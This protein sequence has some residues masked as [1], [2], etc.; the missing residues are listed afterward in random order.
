M[1]TS[2]AASA[3]GHEQPAS[4]RPE[5]AASARAPRSRSELRLSPRT[6]RTR[7]AA[8]RGP[9]GRRRPPPLVPRGAR[10]DQGRSAGRDRRRRLTGSR[11]PRTTLLRRRRAELIGD[12]IEADDQ[13][14][15]AF[16]DR[17][18]AHTESPYGSRRRCALASPSGLPQAGRQRE[19]TQ[20]RLGSGKPVGHDPPAPTPSSSFPDPAPLVR[21]LVSLRLELRKQALPVVLSVRLQRRHTHGGRR[22]GPLLAS[23]WPYRFC[24]WV[25]G[26]PSASNVNSL[27]VHGADPAPDRPRRCAVSENPTT[28]GLGGPTSP[29]RKHVRLGARE[30]HP[31]RPTGS[32]R[33][34]LSTPLPKR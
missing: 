19:P 21:D 30:T 13:S 28:S 32:P 15:S 9:S 33:Q 10:T 31:T 4:H 27:V 20:S 5:P 29:R 17:P 34:P 12:V 26:Q 3:H 6:A 11:P 1:P 23:H 16:G 24:A 14:L 18:A 22:S 7:A 25:G 2:G 8:R